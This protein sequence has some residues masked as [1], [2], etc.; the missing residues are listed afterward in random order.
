MQRDLTQLLRYR[1]LRAS[2]ATFLR[3]Q[4]PDPSFLHC[5]GAGRRPGASSEQLGVRSRPGKAEQGQAP[6]L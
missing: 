5:P 4:L 3:Q 2:L 6:P 1:I